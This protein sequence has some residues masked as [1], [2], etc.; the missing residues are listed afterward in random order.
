MALPTLSTVQIRK[1]ESLIGSWRTKL[2]WQL[3]VE[4][5]K[6]N[7]DIRTTRQTL[8]TYSSIKSAYLKKK[9]ELRGKPT[10]E[11]TKFI[12]SDLKNFEQI[13]RLK[14]E[15]EIANKKIEKQLAFIIKINEHSESNPSLRK[16]LNE[17]KISVGG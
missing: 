2:T 12:K 4:K 7:L 9:Q 16:L 10:T 17:V 11:F 6:C 3:L 1:I 5:I 8:D 13:Q 14:A 15:L